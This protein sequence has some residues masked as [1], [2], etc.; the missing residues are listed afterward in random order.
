MA[1]ERVARSGYDN[2]RYQEDDCNHLLGIDCCRIRSV[3]HAQLPCSVQI[4]PRAFHMVAYLPTF[5][6]QENFGA[7]LFHCRDLLQYQDAV[8]QPGESRKEAPSN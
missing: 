8:L 7:P 1:V 6:G 5:Q 3:Q 2:N 4:V